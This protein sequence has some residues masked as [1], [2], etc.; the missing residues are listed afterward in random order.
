M[1]AAPA[2]Y[3]AFHSRRRRGVT[4]LCFLLASTMA[5]GISVYVDSFSVHEWDENLDVGPIAIQAR[6]EGIENYIDQIRVI[7][8]ITKAVLIHG[9]YGVIEYPRNDTYGE[10]MD[11]VD[12]NIMALNEELMDSFPG[13]INLEEGS[14]P[15]TNASEIAINIYVSQYF[16]FEIG[17]VVNFSGSWWDEDFEEVEIIGF[18]SEGADGS[19]LPYNWAYESFAIVLPG[20]ITN[21]EYRIFI[22][23]DRSRLNA[24]NAQGS[25]AYSNGIDN[26]ILATDPRYTPEEP[27]RSRFWTQNR[28]TSGIRT[29]LLW[30]TTQRINQIFRASSIIILIVLVAFLAVRHNVNER[31]FESHILRSRGA[32][33]GD[34]DK[35]I[36]REIMILSIVSCIFGIVLGI[37]MSRIALGATGFFQFDYELMITEP[38]LVSIESFII[39]IVAG[40]ALP[41]LTLGSYRIVYSTKRSVDEE[42]GRLSKMVRGLNFIKWDVLIVSMAGLLLV[43]IFSGGTE[44]Q[45]D[46]FMS[47]ILP[48]IPIPLFLGVASL[49]IKGLRHSATRISQVMTRLVGK[50]PASVG[51]RRIG[52]GA[53][54]GGAAAMVMVLAICLSWNSAI[55]DASLPITKVYQA[56]LDVGADISFALDNSDIDLWDSFVLNVTAHPNVTSTTFVSQTELSLS[57]GWGGFKD[58]LAVDP[59]AYSEIGYHYTGVRLN[60]SELASS[61]ESLATI[62]DGAIISEDIALEYDLEVGDI[63]RATDFDEEAV[64]FTF[65]VI[66]VAKALPEMPVDE[67]YYY[68]DYYIMP[69]PLPFYQSTNIVGQQ[70]VL[71]NREYLRTLYGTLNYTDNYL[72]VSTTAG[73]NGTEIVNSLFETGGD[74]VI[75]QDLWDSVSTQRDEF[76]NDA[77]YKIDRAVDTMMTVLT[78]GT[79][80]GAFAIYAVEGVRTRKRE[81][82]L[83][84]ST[85]ANTN[86]IVKAQGAEML[87]LML[88]SFLILAGYSPIFLSTTINSASAA[89]AT[90]Y[91]IYPIS[92]FPMIP[93]MTIFRVLAFFIGSVILFIIIVAIMS[94][95]INLAETLNASWSEAAPYGEDL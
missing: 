35:I 4:L 55:V 64:A 94:S 95:K 29:Y 72:C 31:R 84:R 46:P 60:E 5:M 63:L 78:V 56:Q 73:S 81:I 30:V 33:D 38:L 59:R 47:L 53:S 27:W 10:Y 1:S 65:R 86:L 77:S 22:D 45:S 42:K 36:N 39:A 80:M 24:F 41:L 15:T 62:L 85:G 51:I 16:D 82:A 90:M 44:I 3:E 14:L 61:L 57:S 26:A 23:I 43:V 19:G 7:D 88:F 32:S 54:S 50:V 83:L 49:S 52:K 75:Y 68:Y 89:T 25:L 87:I 12:G 74:Q 71:I 69:I 58:F 70:R 17:D 93:W 11:Y 37:G 18:Y 21:P 20:I 91:Q 40:I 34:L 13:Y 8:G 79:I 48:I 9:G 67:Y 76:L 6:G 92:V 2:G 28:I 66:G